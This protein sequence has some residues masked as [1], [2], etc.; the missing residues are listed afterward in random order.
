MKYSPSCLIFYV[1]FLLLQYFDDSARFGYVQG[2]LC[3]LTR[4][5]VS[6]I[7]N[8]IRCVTL[9]GDNVTLT[10]T[11]AFHFGCNVNSVAVQAK[12]RHRDTNHPSNNW[13]CKNN[14]MNNIV[15]F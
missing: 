1:T 8:A 3:F 14:D 4:D 5:S 12:A 2:Q 15:N 7:T 9:W 11:T 13:T 6:G 10:K